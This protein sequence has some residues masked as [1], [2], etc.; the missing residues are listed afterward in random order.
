VRVVA[1]RHAGPY[2]ISMWATP[3]V[4]IAMLYVVYSA[5][6]GAA[7]VAPAAVRVGVAP[8]S[9]RLSEVMY[10]ARPEAVRQGARFVAHIAFDRSEPWRVRVVTDGPA[11]GGEVVAQV[12]ATPMP[13]LGPL[14]L[15]L[16]ALPITVIVGLW[17][18]TALARRHAA[19]QDLALASR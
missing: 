13:T 2:V 11:G 10:D 19:D 15:A 6:A 8:V 4:G 1:D 9:G 18:R 12:Q 7:F 17:A 5:P 3:D 16:Y 14:G